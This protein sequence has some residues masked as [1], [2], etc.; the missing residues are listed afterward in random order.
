ME[1]LQWISVMFDIMHKVYNLQGILKERV[2][3]GRR[4]KVGG[5]V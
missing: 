3:N 5:N 2:R 4:V 1:N